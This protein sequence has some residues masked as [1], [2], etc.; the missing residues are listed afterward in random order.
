MGIETQESAAFTWRQRFCQLLNV[1]AV[2]ATLV[3][4]VSISI[5]AFTGQVFT[6]D[7]IFTRIQLWVCVY[8]LA[9]FF[10]QTVFGPRQQRVSWRRLALVLLSIPYLSLVD[11][12]NLQ[13]S[14]ET[15]YL[16]KFLPILRGGVA[17][18]VLVKMLVSN[19]ITGLFIAYLISFFS[20][21]Y[22]QTLIFFIF[23]SAVNPQVSDYPDALWWAAMTVTTVGST[24][25]PVTALGKFCTTLV[26][27]VGMT[28]F[29]IFTV[30]IS[31]LIQ[32]LNKTRR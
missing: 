14:A 1:C 21:I 31:S 25:E 6:D 10:L 5:E 7:S 29:P 27:M 9:D 3:L 19:P 2:I 28:T 30:Y 15:L 18:I 32:N 4:I 20:L 23:E 16:I 8:F 11:H 26:A 13:L 17:L 24:I 22:F 12:F